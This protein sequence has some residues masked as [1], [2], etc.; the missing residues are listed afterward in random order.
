MSTGAVFVHDRTWWMKQERWKRLW[1]FSPATQA[2]RGYFL[3]MKKPN[4]SDWA[5]SL[6]NM[7]GTE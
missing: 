2:M 6:N 5:K 1:I 4:L 3:G 7:V